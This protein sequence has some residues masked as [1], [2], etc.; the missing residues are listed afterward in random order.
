MAPHFDMPSGRITD[1]MLERHK[2]LQKTETRAEMFKRS[3]AGASYVPPHMRPKAEREADAAAIKESLVKR[4]PGRP[5][6][7]HP[8]LC[9]PCRV[10]DDVLKASHARGLCSMHLKRE[11]RAHGHKN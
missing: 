6:A 9:V 7:G 8:N 10:I 11:R 4:K 2:L 3:K 5:H 1:A